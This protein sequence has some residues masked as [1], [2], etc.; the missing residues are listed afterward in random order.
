MRPSGRRCSTRS[1]RRRPRLL[2]LH[3]RRRAVRL[4]RGR[5]LRGVPGVMAAAAG[6]RPLAGRDGRADRPADRPGD[7]A[8]TSVSRRSST[9]TEGGTLVVPDSHGI[10]RIGRH[11]AAHG[12]ASQRQD[13]T[14]RAC[15]AA[16]RR[17]HGATAVAGLAATV[18]FGWLASMTYAGTPA[19]SPATDPAI[20]AAPTTPSDDDQGVTTDPS[21]TATPRSVSGGSSSSGSSSSGV[22]RSRGS[23]HVSTG[24]S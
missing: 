15:Q 19:V 4:S 1:G 6:Q 20:V 17:C 5:G 12:S 7:R 3:P 23:G 8:S 21:P 22:S 13:R 2:D 9:S 18:G 10:H 24:S 16:T 14:P 11:R